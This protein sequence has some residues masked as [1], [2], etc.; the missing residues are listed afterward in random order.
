LALLLSG[1][2]VRLARDAAKDDVHQST[3]RFAVELHNVEE[4]RRLFQG[5][6]FHPCQ[7]AGLGEGFPL[8]V[9][10]S[11]G[12]ECSGDSEVKPSNA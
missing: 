3:K 7:E 4:N 1:A 11:T 5:L 9:G 6:L 2:T 8:N 10:H 12:S